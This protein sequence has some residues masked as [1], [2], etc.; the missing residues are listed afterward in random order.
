MFKTRIRVSVRLLTLLNGFYKM[1][2]HC[3]LCTIHWSC[4][5]VFV[6]AY[7]Y[8]KIKKKASHFRRTLLAFYILLRLDQFIK[9]LASWKVNASRRSNWKCPWRHFTTAVLFGFQH[10]ILIISATKIHYFTWA[11]SLSRKC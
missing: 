1:F 9:W 2:K 3:D 11:G 5:V 7:F 10:M 8:N 4:Y 6:D